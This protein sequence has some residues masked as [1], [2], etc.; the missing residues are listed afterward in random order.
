MNENYSIILVED[1]NLFAVN[2]INLIN[3]DN[4]LKCKEVFGCVEDALKYFKKYQSIDLLILDIGLPG[5]DGISAIGYFREINKRIK[6]LMLTVFDDDENI[7]NSAK[8]GANGYVLKG[9]NDAKI[10]RSI[11]EVLNGGG[12]LNAGVAAR[13]LKYFQGCNSKEDYK[14]TAG[15]LKI[16]NHFGGGFTKKEIAE[17]EG[18]SIHTID[19]HIRN[20]YQK[21]HVNSRAEAVN[22]ALKKGIIM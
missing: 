2:M 16:L 15:E 18:R 22:K 5:M 21:L 14:L 4:E 19:T 1:D 3:S 7:F 20:I 11:H 10:L 9:D 8:A 17:F 12:A 13:M 6:I